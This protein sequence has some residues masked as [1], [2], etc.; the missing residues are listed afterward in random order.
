MIYIISSADYEDYRPTIVEGPEQSDW[1]AYCKSLLA[2]A[3]QRAV[4]EATGWVGMPEIVKHAVKLLED[5]GYRVLRPEDACFFG[6]G[7]IKKDTDDGNR[8]LPEEVRKLICDYNA[9][10]RRKLDA[11]ELDD[12]EG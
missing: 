8:D 11:G 4:K 7:I 1:K 12:D 10:F 6:R 9:E 5:K 2:E 3:S